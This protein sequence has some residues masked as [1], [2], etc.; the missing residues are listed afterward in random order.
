MGFTSRL[1][2]KSVRRATPRTV[3]RAMNPVGTLRSAVTP[4]PL[5]QLSRTLYTVTNP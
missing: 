2:R 3:R 1:V 4:R 5:K